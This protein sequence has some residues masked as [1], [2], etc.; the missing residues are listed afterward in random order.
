MR[1]QLIIVHIFLFT[2]VRLCEEISYSVALL[3]IKYLIMLL[4]ASF[5][6]M[7]R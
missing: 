2:P 6:V 4:N 7:K 5:H 3:K 1:V